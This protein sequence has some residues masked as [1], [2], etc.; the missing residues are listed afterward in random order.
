ME[1]RRFIDKAATKPR[2][3]PAQ[4]PSW[5]SLPFG[6]PPILEGEDSAAYDDLFARVFASVQPADIIEEIWIRDIVDLEWEILRLRRVK[7]NLLAATMHEG[8]ATLL[9]PL[10]DDVEE[11]DYALS[12]GQLAQGLATEWARRRPSAMKK[13][14]RLLA[15]AK[16]TMEAAMAHTF[17]EHYDSIER[18][19]R[20][21]AMAEN[22]R[23]GVVVE[24]G[25]HRT[26][27]AQAVRR[28]VEQ[29]DDADYQVLD[30]QSSPQDKP[31]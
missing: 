14:D 1:R 26:T 5:R 7:V 25:R 13:V 2:R 27:L 4:P 21:I 17:L 8:L 10:H 20:M 23:N 15:S 30:T 3:A 6:P 11:D 9:E 24:I 29:I 16:L 22:R 18:I 28:T 31:R 19:E 12:A